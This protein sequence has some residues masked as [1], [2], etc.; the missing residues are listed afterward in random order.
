MLAGHKFYGR[1]W[2]LFGDRAKRCSN[3][4]LATELAEQGREVVHVFLFPGDL[5]RS[6]PV[7]G[8]RNSPSSGWDRDQHLH[9]DI[10]ALDAVPVALAAVLDECLFK[11]P[12]TG[13]SP[14]SLLA[15][16][17]RQQVAPPSGGLAALQAANQT[18]VRRRVEADREA[19]VAMSAADQREDRARCCQSIIERIAKSQHRA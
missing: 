12:A 16:L 17:S 1:P 15:R 2:T 8:S 6:N 14:E 4:C 13:P 19:S 18:E 3:N 11:A 9:A 7:A 10:A 5:K